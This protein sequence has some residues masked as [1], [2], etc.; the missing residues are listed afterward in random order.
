MAERYCLITSPV[1]HKEEIATLVEA[2]VDE[3]YAGFIPGSWRAKFGYL[4]SINRREIKTANVLSFQDIR[5]LIRQVH[6]FGKKIFLAF[7]ACTYNDIQLKAL[8]PILFSLED[9]QPDGFIISDLGLLL[10]AKEWL[11]RTPLIISSDFG[12]YNSFTLELL[13]SAGIAFKRVIFSRYLPLG[14]M[15]R[16]IS[17]N[18]NREFEAFLM[19]DRC[20]YEGSVC[21][22]HHIA[23]LGTFCRASLSQL[24]KIFFR[25]KASYQEFERSHENLEHFWR[26]ET[27]MHQPINDPCGRPHP[28]CGLCSIKQLQNIG[29]HSLKICGRDHQIESRVKTVRLVKKVLSG[30][31]SSE[32]IVRLYCET[33]PSWY[34]ELCEKGYNCTYKGVK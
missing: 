21:Y 10:M 30:R 22:A 5:S 19:N 27:M 28:G 8:K 16:I 12:V 9:L 1:V 2:G 24:K 32:E 26:H 4:V 13:E 34:P 17:D 6:S 20:P 7:N 11:I 33:Y 18:P 15:K 14:E 29:I 3:F 23:P 25:K 31:L